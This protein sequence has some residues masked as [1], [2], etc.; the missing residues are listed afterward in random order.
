MLEN[1]EVVNILYESDDPS[2]KV[3]LWVIKVMGSI[4]HRI[5]Q[6]YS[7]IELTFRYGLSI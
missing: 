6:D 7:S 1:E 2:R 5:Q 4:A 3:F